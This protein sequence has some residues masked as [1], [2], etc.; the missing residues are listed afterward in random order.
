MSY[1]IT[2]E[3]VWVGALDDRTG[4]LAEKLQALSEGGLSL[5]LIIS[6]RQAIGGGLLFVSPLRTL[7]EIEIAQQAG[8][9]RDHSFR[10]VRI[11]GPDMRGLGARIAKV[12]SDANV[13][14]R[15]FSA[16]A[17]GDRQVTTLAFDNSDD[18]D[19][20]KKLLEAELGGD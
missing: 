7:E 15:G 18:C 9:A 11:E 12:A 14:L 19:K 8:L 6:R 17:L 13:S 4:A 2:K 5:E 3:H 16:L 1:R 20:V 10:A